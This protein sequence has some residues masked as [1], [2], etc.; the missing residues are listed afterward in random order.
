[1]DVEKRDVVIVLDC[2]KELAE[3]AATAGCCLGK[4]SAASSGATLDR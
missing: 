1:M 4:P 3:V 2:G